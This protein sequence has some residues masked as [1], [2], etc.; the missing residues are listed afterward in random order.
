MLVS[1]DQL[2]SS[3]RVWIYQS[4]RPF[5]ETEKSKISES[6]NSFLAGWTAHNKEL[7]SACEIRYN[8]FIILFVDENV[9]GASGCSIDKSVHFIKKL[10]QEFSLSLL[11]RMKFAFMKNGVVQVAGRT[12]FESMVEKGDIHDDTIVFNNLVQTKA[13]LEN[14]WEMPF[15]KSWHRTIAGKVK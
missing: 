2:P 15:Q 11:D 10:E 6:A 12:A 7:K 1:P 8:H 4:D 9:A 13:E 3:S 14:E 5:N